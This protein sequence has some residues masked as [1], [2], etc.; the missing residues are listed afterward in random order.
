MALSDTRIKTAKAKQKLYKL[1]DGKGLYIE[2]TPTGSKRWRFKYRFN[3][4]EKRISLGIYPD[5][6][7]KE[8]RLRRNECRE[9][10]AE[11]IDPSQ[12]RKQRAAKK[13]ELNK[14]TFEAVARE[15][16][17]KQKKQWSE[18]HAQKTLA[19]LEKNI[20]PFMVSRP[21][22]DIK[23]PELLQVLR[24]VEARGA[25]DTAIRLRAI[26]S[27]IFRYAISIGK[28]ERDISADL[29]GALEPAERK[30]FATI[31]EPKEIGALLRAIDGYTGSYIVRHALQLAPLVFVRPGEL[32]HAEWTEFNL[33][34]AEWIIPADK[35]KKKRKH[36][37]PL[38]SQAVDIL[39][40]IHQLTGNARYVFHSER[41]NTRPMSENT[42]NAALRRLG[43]SKE[44]MT[45]HGFRS[46]ASTRLNEQGF[47][48]DWIELQL[49]HS[50]GNSV[51]AAY[52]YAQYLPERKEMM[53]WYSDYLYRL[54]DGAEIIP[55]RKTS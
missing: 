4:K 39:K 32:R 15:W 43:Y 30:H 34:N 8:V 5:V 42:I 13:V 52:N 19:W 33:D 25:H 21:I 40:S 22:A 35:M 3:D 11:G 55:F 46:M 36:I 7:L 1:Y 2:I 10:L 24:K 45:G 53:Q 48:I 54:R 41:T 31:T 18:G 20:F 26:C 16:H 47:N 27:Q 6:S 37:V 49:A 14:N 51:R 28:A 44:Q 17:T 23:P 38:S 50:E 12:A 29:K 9:L